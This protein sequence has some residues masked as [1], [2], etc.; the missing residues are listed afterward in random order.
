MN[1]RDFLLFFALVENAF[2]LLLW[3]DLLIFCPAKCTYG[4]SIF[5]D[6]L[7]KKQGMLIPG[8]IYEV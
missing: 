5:I 2:F 6:Y 4:A 8:K 7:H 3:G 1:C